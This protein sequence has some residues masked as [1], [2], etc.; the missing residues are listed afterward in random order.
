M[1]A[2]LFADRCV[3]CNRCVEVCPANVFDARASGPP[4][5]D[6]RRRAPPAATARPP[7]PRPSSP[8]LPTP[9]FLGRELR[10]AV[11]PQRNVD[12]RH[13]QRRVFGRVEA[14]Q[15]QSVLEVGKAPL[16]GRVGTAKAQSAPFGDRVQGRILK[17]LRSGPFDPGVRRLGEFCAEL[18]D[19]A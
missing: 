18:L 7:E 17:E 11:L 10:P 12:Q 9:Q 14:D 5:A 1:I 6:P 19:E 15:R 13:E 4:N 3:A 2:L 16:V 8:P